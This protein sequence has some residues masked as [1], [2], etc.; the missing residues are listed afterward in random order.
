MSEPGPGEPF[1]FV[2]Y[3]ALPMPTGI[4]LR[5]ARDLL[6]AVRQAP[7]GVLEQHLLHCYLRPDFE[8]S[9]FPNDFAIWAAECLEDLRL[10]EA[11]SGIDP[12][13]SRDWTEIRE[14]LVDVI[15]DA[16]WEDTG[17]HAVRRGREMFLQ[18]SV[19]FVVYTG[20][21]A[22]SLR[23]L[24]ERIAAC[25][26]SAIYHHVHRACFRHADAVNDF[27]RWVRRSLENEALAEEL[28]EIDFPY[29][30]I[31]ELRWQLLDRL[32][33]ELDREREEWE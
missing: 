17:L 24:R 3:H 11:L 2:R 25:R 28:V 12:F 10:A 16:L 26:P 23:E 1:L 33:A 5:D 6:Q 14:R 13:H 32:D 8:V 22:Q 19:A 29:Y 4:Q 20:G 27:S 9:S 7:L 30:T 15:E 21:Q 31:E 18:E